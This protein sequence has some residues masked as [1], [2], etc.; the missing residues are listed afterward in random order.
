MRDRHMGH[1]HGG[2][3]GGHR[4]NGQPSDTSW[5][6]DG[7]RGSDHRPRRLFEHGDL[8][9]VT[10]QL[11]AETPRHGYEII[12]AIEEKSGG[13]Y[14]PS[15]GAVYPTLT[16]LLELGQLDVAEN[17]GERKLYSIT[18]EGK[19]TLVAN[20]KLVDAIFE[21]IARAGVNKGS[22]PQIREAF[23]KLKHAVRQKLSSGAL[24]DDQ[25]KAIAGHLE[26]ASEA[27]EHI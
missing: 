20:R 22:R 1:G 27:I 16:L 11:I 13:A 10:L 14:A 18:E 7:G 25:I 4:R 17:G 2:F 9:L 12:K 15:A 6:D 26:T 23:H 24:G 5:G 3:R 19:A 21:R 8:R